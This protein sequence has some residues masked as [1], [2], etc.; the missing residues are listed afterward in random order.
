MNDVESIMTKKVITVKPTDNIQHVR[1]IFQLYKFHHLV[2]I[3]NGEIVGILSDR[4][5]HKSMSPKLG[6]KDE[7]GQDRKC[8]TQKVKTIMSS[9]VIAIKKELKIGSAGKFMVAK[10]VSCLP[11]ANDDNRLL[12]LVTLRQ[13]TL[14]Y[15]NMEMTSEMH[16]KLSSSEHTVLD[17]EAEKMLEEL[18]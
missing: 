11:V 7:T 13:I 17:K 5:L 15:I 16:E 3:D 9:K 6:T 14:H 4:D 18:E 12:G 1:F 8:L 2:V 10:G